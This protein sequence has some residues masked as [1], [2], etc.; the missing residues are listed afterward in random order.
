M[1]PNL[2][3]WVILGVTVALPAAFIVGEEVI[4]QCRQQNITAGSDTDALTQMGT[5]PTERA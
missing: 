4:P 5:G 1:Q 2:F 3:Q